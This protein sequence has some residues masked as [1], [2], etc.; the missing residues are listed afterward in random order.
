MLFRSI[1]MGIGALLMGPQLIALIIGA[2]ALIGVGVAM[3]AFGGGMILASKGLKEVSTIDWTGFSGMGSAL[4]SVV[5]GLLALSLASMAFLNPVVLLGFLSMIGVI[6]KFASVM[7]PL[8]ESLD[9]GADSMDRFA[10]G[11]QK[12]KTAI[13]G[14]ELNKLEELKELSAALASFSTGAA[15]ANALANFAEA[16]KGGGGG[17]ARVDGGSGRPLVVQLISP[18]GRVLQEQIIEDTSLVS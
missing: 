7:V 10:G 15:L 8:S 9:V 18:N 11:I 12:L 14:L 13:S 17:T 1:M 4:M 16:I 5:P 3:A 6:S 2:A